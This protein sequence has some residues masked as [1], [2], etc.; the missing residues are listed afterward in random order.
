LQP[1]KVTAAP[2]SRTSSAVTK[3]IAG[4]PMNPATNKLTGDSNR[5]CG[6][7]T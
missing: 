4:E 3:F 5:A 1:A 2:P 6:V 7:S